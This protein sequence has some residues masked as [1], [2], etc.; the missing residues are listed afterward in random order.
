M[1]SRFA[2]LRGQIWEIPRAAIPAADRPKNVLRESLRCPSGRRR[3][4]T[5]ALGRGDLSRQFCS[6]LAARKHTW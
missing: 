4:V 1:T 2:N 5:T 6:Q 3:R